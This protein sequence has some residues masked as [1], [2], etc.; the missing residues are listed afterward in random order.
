MS[1]G[2]YR[3]PSPAQRKARRL[4]NLRIE[5]VSSVDVGAGH[6][7]HVA[8]IKRDEYEE[9]GTEMEMEKGLQGARG[10]AGAF[11]I[12]KRAWEAAQEG[13]LSEFDLNTVIRECARVYFDGNLTKLFQ[14]ELGKIF[15]QPRT[16]RKSAAEE[17]ELLAKRAGDTP[18]S[19]LAQHGDQTGTSLNGG[20]ERARAERAAKLIKYFQD[21]GDSYDVAATKAYRAEK[22]ESDQGSHQDEN[23]RP[24]RGMTGARVNGN[25]GLGE[26]DSR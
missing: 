3:K 17:A 22:A 11:S 25:D 1:Y 8:L 23:R 13:R 12:A 2:Y 10:E 20:S 15:L 6:G 14:S 26:E 24:R 18:H 19:R 16:M 9:R 7:V 4:K 5:E 21:Q